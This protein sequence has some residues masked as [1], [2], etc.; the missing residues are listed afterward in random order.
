[1]MRI[2]LTYGELQKAA[3]IGCKRQVWNL[4]TGCRPRYGAD[5]SNDWQVHIDGCQGEAALAKYL[6]VPWNGALGDYGA[7]DVGKWQVRATRHHRNGRLPLHPPDNDED[8]FV[9]ALILCDGVIDLAGQILCR[10]GKRQEF[11]TDPGTGRPAFFVPR[12]VLA[13]LEAP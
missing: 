5:S 2:R 9:L 3:I 6:G 1:M 12:R 13:P 8:M 4:H 7:A 10:D 11:W